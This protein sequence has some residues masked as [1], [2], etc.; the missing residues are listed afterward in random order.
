MRQFWP[1]HA[2]DIIEINCSGK[3]FTL[4]RSTLCAIEGSNLSQ[5]FS[6][7]FMHNIPKDPQGRLYIDF[8]PQCFTIIVDYL[9]NRRLRPDAPVPVVPAKHQQSMDLLAEALK[10]KPFLHDNKVSP[11]HG[12]SLFVTGNVIQAMHPGWQVI[13]STNALP[14]AR[15]SYFEVKILA[16]P[17]TS[18]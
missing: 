1:E 16:N 7:A 8:N 13:S 17:N 10:L 5:M 15:S 4:P 2:T 12:T 6:D 11:V 14:M 9:Q 3:M 18:G